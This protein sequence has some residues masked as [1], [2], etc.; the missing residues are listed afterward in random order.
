[1]LSGIFIYDLGRTGCLCFSMI[2]LEFI[3]GAAETASFYVQNFHSLSATCKICY[4]E[5]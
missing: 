2:S 3:L 1:M 4:L 5:Y